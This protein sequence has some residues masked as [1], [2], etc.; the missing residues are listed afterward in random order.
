MFVGK[1][2]W[3]NEI[4]TK[5]AKNSLLLRFGVKLQRAPLLPNCWLLP[6][7]VV[8]YGIAETRRIR[9]KKQLHALLQ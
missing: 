6:P 5:T 8:D 2:R 3:Y 9:A 4:I 7:E 1:I